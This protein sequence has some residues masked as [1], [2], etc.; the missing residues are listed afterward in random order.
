MKQDCV[1]CLMT[2]ALL[3]GAGI[4]KRAEQCYLSVYRIL[5]EHSP[6]FKSERRSTVI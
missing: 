2:V 6:L 4:C 3:V 1:F 5:L